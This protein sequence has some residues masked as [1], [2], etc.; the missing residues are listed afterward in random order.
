MKKFFLTAIASTMLVVPTIGVQAAPIVPM[1][2]A[3]SAVQTVNHVPGHRVIKRTVIKRKPNG[4]VVKRTV[5]KHRW[6]RG[7]RFERWRNYR[8]VDYRRYH[9]RRPP[10]GHRWV[11]VDN[12]Y[13]LIAIGSGLIASIIAAR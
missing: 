8:E 7:N 4:T 13:L 2:K 3:D 11:R 6:E 12:D 9:L 10:A 5:K 1:V